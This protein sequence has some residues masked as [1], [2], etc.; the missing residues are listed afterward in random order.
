MKTEK[1]RMYDALVPMTK[2]EHD[3]KFPLTAPTCPYCKKQTVRRRRFWARHTGV[4]C[5]TPGCGGHGELTAVFGRD[6][7]SWMKLT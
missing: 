5:K 7:W 2:A 3:A 6:S 4:R 1:G